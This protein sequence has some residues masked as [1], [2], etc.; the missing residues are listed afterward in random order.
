MTLGEGKK[1]E[2]ITTNRS[3]VKKTFQERGLEYVSEVSLMNV[4]DLKKIIQWNVE[5][6]I[7]MYRMS[8]DMFPWCSEYEFQDLP[9]I[10]E[11]KEVLAECGEIVNQNGHRITFHP[12][13]Y[14]VLGSLNP[15]VVEK[16]K[17]ELRQHSEIMD[18]MGLERSHK[19]PINIHLNTAKPDKESSANRFC[20]NFE[21]LSDS[22][23]SRLVVEVDDKPSQ[24]TSVDLYNLVFLKVKTPITFD[25]HHDFCNRPDVSVEESLK[26][27]ISTWPEGVTPLTHYSGSRRIFEDSS[28][29]EVAH[30]DWIYEKIET[31]GL[32]F[33]I[34]LE[35]KMKEKALLKYDQEIEKIL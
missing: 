32:H 15:S 19:F 24:F 27:C 16:A 11:I 8:S 30:S 29:K 12:S 9:N 17:K 13:P 6:G 1:S 2:R 35:V 26:I 18:F 4:K 22:V 5:R 10:S 25:Y 33:D 14:C 21:D 28:A 20:K 34:E 7:L 23:K 31:F 3:M